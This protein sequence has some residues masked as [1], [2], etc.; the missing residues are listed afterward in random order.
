VST[1]FLWVILL[2]VVPLAA[3]AEYDVCRD[4]VLKYGASD[5]R[6]TVSPMIDVAQRIL[7][8][9]LAAGR[10]A[11]DPSTA[12]AHFVEHYFYM[13]H[14][15]AVAPA[16]YSRCAPA[17]MYQELSEAVGDVVDSVR[18]EYR[19]KHWYIGTKE[20]KGLLD[21]MLLANR[22]DEFEAE[23]VRFLRNA[24]DDPNAAKLFEQTIGLGTQR[25]RELEQ[26]QNAL[27]S[28]STTLTGG[29]GLFDFELS[30]LDKLSGLAN[31][32]NAYRD[33]HVEYWLNKETQSFAAVK[34]NP[35][36]ASAVIA[37]VP[38]TAVAMTQLEQA[39]K[40]ARTD[41]RAPVL[42][43]GEAR[44]DWLFGE[45]RYSEAKR[46]FEFAG[47]TGKQTKAAKLSEEKI[48]ELSDQT[49]NKVQEQMKGM[50]KSKEQKEAFESD[51]D[52]LAEELGI[53]LDDF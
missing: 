37:V 8:E 19:R 28:R 31:R 30:G 11:Q 43:I 42:A 12:V 27:D 24:K 13:G 35:P 18:D 53:D 10:A 36:H 14:P 5:S 17:Q 33:E 50:I 6:E 29:L 21:M 48:A 26:F 34:R 52:S 15:E 22:Y 3:P 25:A 40:V 7:E 45:Q 9:D 41:A 20:S 2:S 44:G 39:H 51:T 38:E 46:Y 47:A 16:S 4:P 49:I 32:L 23:A 1:Q